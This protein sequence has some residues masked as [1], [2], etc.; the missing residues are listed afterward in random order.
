MNADTWDEM[1]SELELARRE[2]NCA[3]QEDR[4][5]RLTAGALINGCT[6]LYFRAYELEDD[7]GLD[8]IRA[9]YA[10]LL[11]ISEE[12]GIKEF[13]QTRWKLGDDLDE[14]MWQDDYTNDRKLVVYNIM[15][16]HNMR[17]APEEYAG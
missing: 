4:V 15:G 10:E 8:I 11:T 16:L 9:R 3:K 13:V 17:P 12:C 14:S 7:E 6:L 1:L 2:A 5:K